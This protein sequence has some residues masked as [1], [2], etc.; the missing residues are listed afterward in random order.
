MTAFPWRYRCSCGEL[1]EVEAAEAH[2][3]AHKADPEWDGV[4]ELTRVD[5]EADG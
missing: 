2:L 3:A 1:I 5:A 4:L